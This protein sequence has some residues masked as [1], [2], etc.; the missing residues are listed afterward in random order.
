MWP[1]TVMSKHIQWKSVGEERAG[2]HWKVLS[3]KE[4]QAEVSRSVRGD[5]MSGKE[6]GYSHNFNF[7]FI[8][9]IRSW[10]KAEIT[11]VFLTTY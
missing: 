1:P 10:L 11:S 7:T 2:L 4:I 5:G 6:D 8:C 3:G 9:T